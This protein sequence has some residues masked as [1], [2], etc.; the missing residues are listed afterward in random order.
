MDDFPFEEQVICE[1]DEPGSDGREVIRTFSDKVD[2]AD[3][4]WHRD[5]E[6]RNITVLDS[7][8]WQFQLEDQ[9]PVKLKQG[10]FLQIPPATYHRVIKGDG[11][12]VV[13]IWMS[14]DK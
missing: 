13:Y 7:N 11:P 3:L 2:P 4:I 10:D 5:R 1:W 8:G 12:L 9:L 14:L 6:F